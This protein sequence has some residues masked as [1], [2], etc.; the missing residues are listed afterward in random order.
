M[1]SNIINLQVAG[2][3]VITYGLIGVT[4]AVLA[5]ATVSGGLGDMAAKSVGLVTT[6]AAGPDASVGK[7]EGKSEDIGKEDTDES[8]SAA[9]EEPAETE[10]KP[11]DEVKGGNRR[12]HQRRTPKSKKHNNNKTKSHRHQKNRTNKSSRPLRG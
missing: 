8:P 9:N 5:Y 10:P 11:A 3:P 12:K 1:S 2:I 6:P 7:S 4:T